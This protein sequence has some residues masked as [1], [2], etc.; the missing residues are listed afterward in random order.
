MT[1]DSKSLPHHRVAP[2]VST[3]YPTLQADAHRRLNQ[4]E[5][6]APDLASEEEREKQ[7]KPRCLACTWNFVIPILEE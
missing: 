6:R 3:E 7:P 2:A 5:Q 4:V 1:F